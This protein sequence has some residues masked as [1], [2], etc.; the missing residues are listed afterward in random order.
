MATRYKRRKLF[1]EDKEEAAH[2]AMNETASIQE[3][4][5][6]PEPDPTSN[7]QHQR[8]LFVRSL[9]ATTTTESLTKLFSESYPLKHAVVVVDPVTKQS[10][11]YGFVT[12]TDAEDAH[13]AKKE[14][15]RFLIEG[16][17]IRVT[18]AEP[19]HREVGDSQQ[20]DQNGH[21]SPEAITS[22]Y[23]KLSEES[24]PPKLIVRNLPWTLKEPKQLAALFRSYGTVK[25]AT[26]PQKKAGLQ[27][28][29]GFVVLRGKKNAEKALEGVNGKVVDGR[30]LAV[31]WA[32]EKAEWETLQKGED[33]GKLSTY[34]FGQSAGGD[35]ASSIKSEDEDNHVADVKVFGGAEQESTGVKNEFSNASSIAKSESREE[36]M[37]LFVRNL[38]FT[39]TDDTLREHFQSFG[40]VRYARVVLD[41]ATERSRGAGFVC[42]YNQDDATAC[43]QD[44]PRPQLASRPFRNGNAGTTSSIKSSI[45]E[46]L[47]SDPSGNFTLEGRVLQVSKAVDRKE[48]LRLTAVG[49]STRNVRDRDRRRLYLLSEGTVP[50]NSLLYS[51]LAPSEIKM[52]E[53][54]AKQRQALVKS[55]PAL[56]LSLTRLSIRNIPRSV[57]SKDLKALAREAVVGFASNVKAGLRQQLSKEEM[58]RGGDEMKS[59]ERNRKLK[60]KGIVKQAKIVFEG[61][62]GSKVTEDS[63][64]GRSRGYGFIEYVSHR[65][66]LMGLR[67]LN[68]HA[69]VQRLPPGEM[70]SMSKEDGQERKKRII[71]EFALENSQVVGR[72][73]EREAKAHEES[74]ELS[75]RKATA[76]QTIPSADNLSKDLP[77]ESPHQ[78]IKRKRHSAVQPNRRSSETF[79]SKSG[80]QTDQAEDTNN[81]SKRQ[82]IIAK[83]RTMRRVAKHKKI[84]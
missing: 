69:M 10:K 26:I 52:R 1:L 19:R 45:L 33:Q 20:K 32:I 3:S 59:A 39:A 68:G 24:R 12:F 78:G 79:A 62:E 22:K 40:S 36:V 84:G 38:P 31:D 49:D 61:R 82:R 51:Q 30:T 11:C 76:G 47:R 54:S 18:V 81:L 34:G 17:K 80:S 21:V 66:A 72:R 8:S 6:F 48:A 42:F 77:I 83:K 43:L 44:A 53:D 67:W 56:N 28:G 15:D 37:T 16:R 4:S 71:V 27:S 7:S 29:F 35:D 63:G 60:G 50:L 13:L 5:N 55:N 9:P 70:G 65:W 14:F 64:A 73:Q 41:H 23:R 46:D 58:S 74:K 25:H 75:K 57:T 2:S